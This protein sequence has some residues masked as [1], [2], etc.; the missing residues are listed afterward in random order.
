MRSS[1]LRGLALALLVG[2]SS[3]DEPPADTVDAHG[4][5]TEPKSCNCC[6]TTVQLTCDESP[7]SCNQ[8][9]C[10][11][12]CSIVRE[13]T[14]LYD[15]EDDVSTDATADGAASDGASDVKADGG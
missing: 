6:G 15:A 3:K 9:V 1:V 2:C 4:C 7:E 14:G 13:E 11:P 5:E 10:D 8:G 12:W